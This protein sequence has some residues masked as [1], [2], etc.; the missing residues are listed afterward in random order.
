MT[1]KNIKF[2][3]VSIVVFLT[4]LIW[5]WAD[6]AQDERL[7]LS[8]VVVEVAKSSNPALWVS[9]VDDQ[10]EPNLQTSVTL[11]SVVL[12]GPASRVAEVQRLRNKGSLDLSLFL[13][14]DREG[15]T[16]TD[17]HVLDVMDFLR[18]SD[19]IRRL[20][21]AVEDCKPQRLTVR[22]QEL[23]KMS[24]AVECAGLDPSVQVKIQPDTVE[25]YVPQEEA[26]VRTATVRLL[27]DEQNRAKNVPVEKT[28]YIELVPG[29]RREVSTKVKVTLAPAEK[30]LIDDRV[31][32]VLGFCF[33][34]NMQGKFCIVL[35]N[36]DPTT[37]AYVMVQA[38]GEASKLY[39]KMMF[40]MILY[41]R[42]EDRQATEPVISREV[43]FNFPQ[44]SV[45]AGEIRANQPAPTVRFRLEPIAEKNASSGP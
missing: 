42:D 14:A 36:D 26:G 12:K 37:R 20:G 31:P 25:A 43:V 22:V 32:A 40:Q 17:V 35:E 8:D 34:Q 24:V 39:A 13:I 10:K 18:Q 15:M 9:F 11:D 19:D 16:K 1:A 23:V 44:E 3:K 4:I 30:S 29:Q 5:V 28:P 27:A 45:Q 21:L 7:I 6:L 38:T 41:I 33:S 2:G